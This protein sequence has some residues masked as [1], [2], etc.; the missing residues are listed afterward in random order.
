MI[1]GK[2]KGMSPVKYRIHSLKT[3]ATTYKSNA[4]SI[5]K[6]LTNLINTIDQQLTQ[7]IS[8]VKVTEGYNEADAK[9]AGNV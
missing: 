6:T 8:D 3:L 2:L 7:A 4:G 9:R 5:E 1:K